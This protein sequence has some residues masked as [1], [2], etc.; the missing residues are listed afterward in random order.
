[1]EGFDEEIV[2]A[3][4]HGGDGA[5][6]VLV[7]GDDDEVDVR[8]ARPADPEQLEPIHGGEVHVGDDDVR[9]LGGQVLEG[10]LRGR[11][12]PDLVA[13]AGEDA[14]HE[15]ADRRFVIDDEDVLA[16][17]VLRWIGRGWSP[18][19][20]VLGPAGAGAPGTA[21]SLLRGPGSWSGPGPP[22]GRRTVPPRAFPPAGVAG[23]RPPPRVRGTERA[24]GPRGGP[25]RRR[26]RVP[27]GGAG[28]G[29]VP[30]VEK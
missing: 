14:A 18:A 9:R 6:H 30:I 17:S 11:G 2:G 12:G 21:R 26:S 19:R 20:A 15:V 7:A 5:A 27:W 25:V 8:V 23:A 16:H 1:V 3:V 4:A 24:A 29:Q 10:G 13:G 28:L 22:P